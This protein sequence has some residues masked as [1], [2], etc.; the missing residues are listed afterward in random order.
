MRI[1]Y[2]EMISF[3]SNYSDQRVGKSVKHD[4]QTNLFLKKYK[5]S[6]AKHIP[7]GMIALGHFMLELPNFS[8]K[9]QSK[10]SV[11]LN[12]CKDAYENAVKIGKSEAVLYEFDFSLKDALRGLSEVNFLLGEYRQRALSYKYASY[13]E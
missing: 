3:Q 4:N 12:E 9:L 5:E 6:F 10:F 13:V 1:F 2:E 11:Y 7:Y 8:E